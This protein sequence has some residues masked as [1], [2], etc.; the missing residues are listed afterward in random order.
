V[1]DRCDGFGL[2]CGCPKSK[3]IQRGIGCSLLRTPEI[4][5]DIIAQCS[6]VMSKPIEV[7]IRLRLDVRESVELCRRAE[8]A[9]ASWITV[10]A[11]QVKVCCVFD[12]RCVYVPMYDVCVIL[13][14]SE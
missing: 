9:G 11:R 13:R 6:A 4:V 3:H 5:A 8:R 1:Y 12:D 10:H 2:N 7:K 14:V